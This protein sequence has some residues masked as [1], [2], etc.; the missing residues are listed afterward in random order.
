MVYSFL[1]YRG[2]N[3]CFIVEEFVTIGIWESVRDRLF[4]GFLID[5]FVNKL[6]FLIVL[7]EG[8]FFE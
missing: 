2:K 7:L 3:N 5:C 4:G 8:F 1:Y 6:Y